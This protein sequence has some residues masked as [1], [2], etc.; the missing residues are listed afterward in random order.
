MSQPFVCFEQFLPSAA[1]DA[2]LGAALTAAGH[3]SLI[4]S[5]TIHSNTNATVVDEGFR[6]SWTSALPEE[7]W[8]LFDRPLRQ[9]LPF[10][11]HELGLEWFGFSHIERALTV[12]GPGDFFK[13]H[14]DNGNAA[15]ASRKISFVYHCHVQPRG[16]EGGELR[17]HP[18]PVVDH[19]VTSPVDVEPTDNALVCFPAETPHEV[20]AVRSAVAPPD[21]CRFTVNGWFHEA[22]GTYDAVMSELDPSRG[23][24]RVDR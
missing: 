3:E 2:V 1:R 21:G 4:R 22:P 6:S 24:G 14:S 19:E 12:H 8:Q 11:R 15:T 18:P 17:L 5:T 23:T 13:R 20:L 16:F 7:I 10:L 9:L